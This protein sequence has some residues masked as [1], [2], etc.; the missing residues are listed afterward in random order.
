MNNDLP[1]TINRFTNLPLLRWRAIG[2]FCLLWLSLFTLRSSW[3]VEDTILNSTLIPNILQGHGVDFSSIPF[4]LNFESSD[5]LCFVKDAS[6][7]MLPV[8]PIGMLIL[9]APIQMIVWLAAWISGAVLDVTD[10]SFLATRLAVEKLSAAFLTALSVC[11]LYRTLVI[12]VPIQMSL[13]IAALYTFGS[14]S[15]SMLSQGLWPHTGINFLLVYLSHLLLRQEGQVTRG[16][17]LLFFAALGI[18]CG[19]RPT[20]IP[21]A[22]IFALV[23]VSLFGRPRISAILVGLLMLLPA[24][25]WNIALFHNILGGY[26]HF[27]YRRVELGVYQCLSRLELILFSPKR[28]LITFNPFLVFALWAH[29]PIHALPP[30]RRTVLVGLVACVVCHYL[31]CS[32]N[33]EWHG[34]YSFGPR[35][36]LDVLAPCF[37][38]AAIGFN[39]IHTRLPRIS[40]VALVLIMLL[41]VALH[42]FGVSGD[43]LP[44]AT[45][46]DTYQSLLVP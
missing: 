30:K 20:A 37:L 38:V 39:A 43:Q 21:F 10:P 27:A 9:S 33:P 32:T 2:A 12:F 35:Y 16:S 44:A 24:I 42:I 22:G 34:G 8:H 3:T 5:D 13:V 6:G 41:S 25:V 1:G 18:L 11:Y 36:M 31:L 46:R 17:E 14:S 45:L 40:D 7:R 26:I 23:F 28:G 29:K 4:G 19:I 15:L